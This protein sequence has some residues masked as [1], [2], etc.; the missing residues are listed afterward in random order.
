MKRNHPYI[1][2]TKSGKCTFFVRRFGINNFGI[3]TETTITSIDIWSLLVAKGVKVFT[4]FDNDRTG[5]HLAWLY[6]KTYGTIPLF[7]TKDDEKDFSDN[8]LKYGKQ[9]MIEYIDYVRDF[10]NIKEL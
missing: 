10:F 4:L 5:K 7:F 9:Y 8:L 2:I 1:V 3:L 6:R